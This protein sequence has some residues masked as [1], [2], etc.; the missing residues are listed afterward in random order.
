M[1]SPLCS[2]LPKYKV[3]LFSFRALDETGPDDGG[4]NE[5][6]WVPSTVG[7]T[8]TPRTIA[9]HVFGNI[10]TGSTASFGVTEGCMYLSCSGGAAPFGIGVSIQLWERDN[11]DLAKVLQ[12]TSEQFPKVGALSSVVSAPTWVGTALPIVGGILEVLADLAKDDL[13]ASQTY[14]YSPDF[15]AAKLPTVGSF[16]DVRRYEDKTPILGGVYELTTQVTR[17]A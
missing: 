5:P 15:L 9:S 16:F 10:D 4:S 11:N 12:E 6:Y 7:Q 3:K 13:I 14:A 17:V 1:T 8:G 2:Q